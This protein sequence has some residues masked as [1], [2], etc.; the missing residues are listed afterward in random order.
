MGSSDLDDSTIQ[1]RLEAYSNSLDDSPI[2]IILFSQGEIQY[3]NERARKLLAMG[4]DEL[5]GKRVNELALCFAIK[6]RKRFIDEL[7][8]LQ[9]AEHTRKIVEDTLRLAS[10]N[11]LGNRVKVTLSANLDD[12]SSQIVLHLIEGQSL[13]TPGTQSLLRDNYR[14]L[15][16]SISLG[17]GY[18]SQEGVLLDFNVKAAE[19]LGGKPKDFIGKSMQELFG[20]THGQVYLDRLKAALQSDEPIEYEDEVLLVDQ[21]RWFHTSYDKVT[22]ELGEIVGVQVSSR[23]ITELK[24]SERAFRQSESVLEKAHAISNIG[25]Y[26][27]DVKT[28]QTVWSKQLRRIL[29]VEDDEASY[30]RFISL[31][32]PDDLERT[33]EKGTQAREKD[34]ILELEYRIVRPDGR[35]RHIRDTADVSYGAEGKPEVMVG[36]SRDVTEQKQLADHLETLSAAVE[37]SQVSVVITDP[38]GSIEYVNKKFTDV[39]GYTMQEALGENPSILKSGDQSEEVYT[40]LWSTIAQGKSWNGEFKNRKKN[41]EAYWESAIISPVVNSSGS[42]S[43]YIA[44]KEDITSLK[45]TEAERQSLEKQLLQA[46]KLESIGTLTSGIAHDFNNILQ[47]MFLYLGIVQSEIGRENP[48]FDS[49]QRVMNS[50]ERAREL[51]SQLSLFSRQSEHTRSPLAIG[52]I[53]NETLKMIRATTPATISIHSSIPAELPPVLCSASEVHQVFLNLCNNA[54]QAIGDSHGELHISMGMENCASNEDNQCIHLAVK[55]NGPGIESR[56][57]EKVFDPFFTTKAPGKGTGLGLSVVHG[58]MKSLGGR[59]EV[60]SEMDVGSVFDLFFP[61][62]AAGPQADVEAGKSI[63]EIP[64]DL[65]VLVVDDERTIVNSVRDILKGRGYAVSATHS[66]REAL[67]LLGDRDKHYDLLLTDLYMQDVSGKAIIDR[68]QKARPEL[69]IILMSGIIENE[70]LEPLKSE[71]VVFLKK[72]WTIGQLIDA[73]AQLNWPRG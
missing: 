45:E 47:S 33:L 32:H 46:Q 57:L 51:V 73:I 44:L 8:G 7:E 2:G 62:H 60:R 35:I 63:D 36:V 71:G 13:K 19:N 34:G 9:S 4:R 24:K 12:T 5:I 22:D 28:N 49:F 37:Q 43:H 17:I 58:I 72:P 1:S 54:V 23:D 53:I 10:S 25:S 15:F 65:K 68:A 70:V 55:D 42:I 41:G 39:T 67:E 56:V 40:E 29:G 66:S 64:S 20:E 6:D 27:W 38:K 48:L 26:S 16:N 11:A 50:A 30:E 3:H 21:P 18:F 31:I 14:Y 52:P 61:V 69:P 59:I